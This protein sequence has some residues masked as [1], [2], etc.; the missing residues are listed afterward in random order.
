MVYLYSSCILANGDKHFYKMLSKHAWGEASISFA[1]KLKNLSSL[2]IIIRT[3]C[4]QWNNWNGICSL[5]QYEIIQHLFRKQDIFIY[6]HYSLIVSLLISFKQI[7][8]TSHRLCSSNWNWNSTQWI[9]E[10]TFLFPFYSC[11][12]FLHFEYLRITVHKIYRVYFGKR[13]RE[14]CNA[15]L[16]WGR[17]WKERVQIPTRWTTQPPNWSARLLLL[18]QIT[19][20]TRECRAGGLI[21]SRRNANAFILRKMFL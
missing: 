7:S 9:C 3:G 20:K 11:F 12:Y 21:L 8:D 19:S 2:G 4:Q 14:L 10:V 17:L 18:V 16:V 5:T 6:H 1:T 13:D 15:I